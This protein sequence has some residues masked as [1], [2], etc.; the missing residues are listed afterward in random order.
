M[1]LEDLQHTVEFIAALRGA[2]LETKMVI[3]AVE[4]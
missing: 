4:E 3:G 2:S 1:V